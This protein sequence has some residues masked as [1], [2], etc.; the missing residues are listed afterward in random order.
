MRGLD[1]KKNGDSYVL[2]TTPGNEWVL[3][4][5][6]SSANA[7]SIKFSITVVVSDKNIVAV[8]NA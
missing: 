8:K 4:Y 1:T 5:E 7:P 2:R 6:I 3:A